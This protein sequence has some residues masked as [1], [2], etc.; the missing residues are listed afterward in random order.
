MDETNPG[1]LEVLIGYDQK[2][3]SVR[4]ARTANADERPE[5]TFYTT[6][7]TVGLLAPPILLYIT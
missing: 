7:A 1:V 6:V 3:Y 5:R 4:T 2:C